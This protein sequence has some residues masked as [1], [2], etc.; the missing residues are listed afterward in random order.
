MATLAAKLSAAIIKSLSK[1][2]P[3]AVAA[4]FN[5]PVDD[6]STFL[7]DFLQEQ[8]K[9][10][11]KSKGKHTARVTGYNMYC[12]EVRSKD[13]SI[14]FKAAGEQWRA[15][16]EDAKA[17]WEKKAVAETEAR[18]QNPQAAQ[19]KPAKEKKPRGITGYNLFTKE[20]RSRNKSITTTQ[21]GEQWS[22]L[23]DAEKLQWK[24]KADAV[25][26]VKPNNSESEG[27]EVPTASQLPLQSSADE[28]KDAPKKKAPMPPSKGKEEV[29]NKVATKKKAPSP[30]SSDGEDE[31]VKKVTK[32]ASVEIVT[33]AA[34]KKKV[35]KGTLFVVNDGRKKQIIGKL[36]GGQVVDLTDADRAF[37]EK[38]GWKVIQSAAEILECVDEE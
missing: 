30:P 10:S 32:K 36:V 14:D 29:S 15:L 28:V 2:L 25:N 17:E 31:P 33:D 35:I 18:A 3:E 23:G 6:F 37:C 12:K 20:I 26:A 11:S 22:A 38:K 13:K 7:N 1:T 9:T 21:I 24:K 27:E 34:T 16:D 8:L 19:K 4:K 5:I